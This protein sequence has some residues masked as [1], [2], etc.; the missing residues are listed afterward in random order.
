[1]SLFV[2]YYLLQ[3]KRTF[4]HLNRVQMRMDRKC[5]NAASDAMPYNRNKRIKEMTRTKIILSIRCLGSVLNVP[6]GYL[7][8]VSVPLPQPSPLSSSSEP[9][10]MTLWFRCLRFAL[11]VHST[12]KLIDMIR[13]WYC[14]D[15]ASPRYIRLNGKFSEILVFFLAFIISIQ[16]RVKKKFDGIFFSVRIHTLLKYDELDRDSFYGI[17]DFSYQYN[18]QYSIFISFSITLFMWCMCIDS[19]PQQDCMH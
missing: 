9:V 18:N 17:V 2:L 4:K 16:K 6:F 7:L 10:A 14:T 19:K 15:I 3:L 13:L 1:M 8:S 11:N 12:S 5:S